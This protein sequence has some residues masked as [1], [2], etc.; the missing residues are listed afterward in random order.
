MYVNVYEQRTT[1]CK[2]A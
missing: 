2:L 1:Q